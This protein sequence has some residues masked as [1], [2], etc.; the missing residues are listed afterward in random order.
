[1]AFISNVHVHTSG[2]IYGGVTQHLVSFLSLPLCLK[3]VDRPKSNIF[4]TSR[5]TN[6]KHVFMQYNK[7]AQTIG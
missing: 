2:A 1:M 6:Y 7:K 3:T 4:T 5:Q